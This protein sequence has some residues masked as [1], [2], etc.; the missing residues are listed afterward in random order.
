MYD[1]TKPYISEIE[2]LI[3]TTWQTKY[4]SAHERGVFQKYN[5]AT[6]V[7][8]RHTD[9]IGTKGRDHWREQTL[10][11]AVTDALAANFNDFAVARAIPMEVCDHIFLP[12]DDHPAILEIVSQLAAQCSKWDIAITAGEM[13]IHEDFEGLE[14]S[15]T[16]LGAKRSFAAN[17]F[18]DGDVLIGIESSGPHANGFTL[19]HNVYG[20]KDFPSDITT[21]TFIYLKH[22]EEID[23]ACDI[24]GM[25]NITGGAFTKIKK[26]LGQHD[27]Y[28]HRWHSLEPHDIF[29]DLVRRGVPERIMYK[30]F[31]CG[32]GFIIGVSPDMT[33]ACF[34]ILKPDFN[35]NIIGKVKAG[36]GRVHIQSMFSDT[37]ILL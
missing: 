26:Y 6:G 37:N 27:A 5:P 15:I 33:K 10:A 7:L 9:G 22:I 31:N 18:R 2:R 11:F 14:I 12:V 8:F 23:N 25:V 28:I 21:P 13:A 30:T 1:T 24:H 20:D 3:Q 32:I 34:S 16:M 4:V 19:I 36:L 17:Q 35:A 29:W